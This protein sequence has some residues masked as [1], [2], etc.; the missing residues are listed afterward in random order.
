MADRIVWEKDEIGPN[1]ERL[2]ENVHRAVHGVML[3]HENRIQSHMRDNAPW[4]DQTA[5]ARNGL[6]ARAYEDD[7]GGPGRDSRGRFTASTH[8]HGIVLFHSVPYGI[9]LEVRNSGR[10][11]IILPTIEEKAPEVMASVRKLLARIG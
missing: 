10:Y 2:P 5:N 1:L 6:F 9:W 7:G 8:T 11:A 3:F 4:T